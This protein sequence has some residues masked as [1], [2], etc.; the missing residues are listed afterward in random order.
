MNLQTTRILF[1][2]CFV[3]FSG[4]DLLGLLS[5]DN[6]SFDGQLLGFTVRSFDKNIAVSDHPSLRKG[7]RRHREKHTDREGGTERKRNRQTETERRGKE[8]GLCKQRGL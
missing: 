5:P 1:V 2:S 6:S 7:E 4:R 3:H 8:I